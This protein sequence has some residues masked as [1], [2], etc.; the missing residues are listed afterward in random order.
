M[1]SMPVDLADEAIAV[2]RHRP[3]IAHHTTVTSDAAV[4]L[5]T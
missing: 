3:F 4:A 1:L 5:A 2:Y